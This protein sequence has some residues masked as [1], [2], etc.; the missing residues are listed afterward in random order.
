MQNILQ[1]I[2]RNRIV[3]LFLLLEAISFTLIFQWNK[4]HKAGF[5][6]SANSVSGS[7]LMAISDANDYFNLKEERDSLASENA[8]LRSL[9]KQSYYIYNDSGFQM[10]DSIRQLQYF[11]RPA[12]VI[13]N[14]IYNRNNYITI[15]RGSKNGI[16]ED[17]GIICNN[18]VVGT[19]VSVSDHFSVAISFL[20]E[21]YRLGVRFN[22]DNASGSF[23]GWDGYNPA[24][25]IIKD[26]PDYAKVEVGDTVVAASASTL[27]PDGIMVG[28]V[29]EFIHTSGDESSMARINLSVPFGRLNYV[30]VIENFKKQEQLEVEQKA[31]DKVEPGIKEK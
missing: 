30:Y 20:H 21:K 22:R 9:Q 6:N 27:F 23:E 7:I 31:K 2:W 10:N 8:G 12:K 24:E 29:K 28:T 3:F 4:Y 17:M 11:Y 13:N 1:F 26:I 14:T 19:I 18:G 25:A 16:R 15:N 5:I